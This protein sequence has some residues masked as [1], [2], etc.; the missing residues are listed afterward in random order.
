MA[1]AQFSHGQTWMVSCSCDGP[2]SWT[3]VAVA[4]LLFPGGCA[5]ERPVIVSL[6]SSTHGAVEVT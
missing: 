1:W 5:A 6:M 2:Q 4:E 3:A